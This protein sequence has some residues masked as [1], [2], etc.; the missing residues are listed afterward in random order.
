MSYNK[1]KSKNQNSIKTLND[2]IKEI[3]LPLGLV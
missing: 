1:T 2:Y 3:Y